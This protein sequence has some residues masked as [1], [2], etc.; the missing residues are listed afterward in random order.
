VD[1]R[2]AQN[3][4]RNVAEAIKDL[5]L[6]PS[7]FQ[8]VPTDLGSGIRIVSGSDPNTVRFTTSTGTN[9]PGL[10]QLGNVFDMLDVRD[11]EKEIG[12]LTGEERD[13]LAGRTNR[14]GGISSVRQIQENANKI[15]QDA[16][17]AYKNP[18][19]RLSNNLTMHIERFKIRNR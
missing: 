11:L 10:N 7:E 9:L 8:D 14:I 16:I 12:N 15:R 4:N 18:N 19:T 13:F 6:V 3:A 1:P 5:Q 2:A 17:E